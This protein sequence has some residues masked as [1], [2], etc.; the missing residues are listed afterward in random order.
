MNKKLPLKMTKHKRKKMRME[1][2][3]KA[4]AERV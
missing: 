2:A 3:A 1:A 4:A